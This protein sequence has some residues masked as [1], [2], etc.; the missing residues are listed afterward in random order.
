VRLSHG[1]IRIRGVIHHPKPTR[2]HM[3]VTAD[4]SSAA[5]RRPFTVE[6]PT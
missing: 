5:V 4:M 2:T 1:P 3:A 6:L